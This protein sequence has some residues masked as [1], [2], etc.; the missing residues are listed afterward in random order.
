MSDWTATEAAIQHKIDA[1]ARRRLLDLGFP[2]LDVFLRDRIVFLLCE[3]FG[4]RAGILLRHIIKA[5][6]GT[7]DQLD[8]DG[9]SFRHGAVPDWGMRS[10]VAEWKRRQVGAQT[11]DRLS[12][13][14]RPHRK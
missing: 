2:K 13:V 9:R 11:S 7:R 8:L 14:N 1:L 3:L 5:G 4:H 6:I 10:G 12:N